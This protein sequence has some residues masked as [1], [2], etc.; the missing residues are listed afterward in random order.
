[1]KK[2]IL[3]ILLTIFALNCYLGYLWIFEENKTVIIPF[4]TFFG[5]AIV[6]EYIVLKKKIEDKV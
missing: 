6:I 3:L 5:I 1:M 4:W 2:I